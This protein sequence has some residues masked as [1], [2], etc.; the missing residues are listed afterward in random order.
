V[1]DSAAQ[2]F[3]IFG[4]KMKDITDDFEAQVNGQLYIDGSDP[5]NEKRWEGLQTFLKFEI[6]AVTDRVAIPSTTAMY[7]GKGIK[8]GTFG[9]AGGWSNLLG[10]GKRWNESLTNDWPD[11]QGPTEFDCTAPLG[12]NYNSTKWPSGAAGWDVNCLEI[13]DRAKAF[14]AKNRGTETGTRANLM[15]SEMICQVKDRARAMQRIIE[16]HKESMDLG[17]DD[18]LKYDG[19]VLKPDFDCPA[20]YGFYIDF[21]SLLLF[22]MHK[23]LYDSRGPEWELQQKGWLFW[24]FNLG[25]VRYN[26]RNFALYRGW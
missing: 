13:L 17:F 23:N 8:L 18:A 22:T 9:G 12:F 19:V 1:N 16:P 6:P 3:D 5:I 4:S 11:G 20:G 24:M 7:A 14:C 26:T 10:A 2:I 25:N 15:T 21:V